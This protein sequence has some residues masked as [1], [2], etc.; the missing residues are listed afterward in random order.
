MPFSFITITLT[1][2]LESVHPDTICTLPAITYKTSVFIIL[3]SKP[4]FIQLVY[5]VIYLRKTKMHPFI[6]I[7]H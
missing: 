1:S 5:Q 2:S 6:D 3:R 4:C 7:Y